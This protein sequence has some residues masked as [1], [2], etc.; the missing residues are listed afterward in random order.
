M[1]DTIDKLVFALGGDLT[2]LNKAYADAEA[3]AQNYTDL[4]WV[5][6]TSYFELLS[7]G[8]SIESRLFFYCALC[9]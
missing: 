4:K 7:N 2:A 5:L 8:N 3:G 1:T 6:V 9:K